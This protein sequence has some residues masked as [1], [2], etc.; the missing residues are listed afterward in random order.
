MSGA[1]QDWMGARALGNGAI[2]KEWRD[3]LLDKYFDG[4]EA[5]LGALL[6]GSERP[7][8]IDIGVGTGVCSL[9]FLG[10]ER[11]NRSEYFGIDINDCVFD[12][13][14]YFLE[15]GVS[16]ESI[17]FQQ[18]DLFDL[19]NEAGQFDLILAEG[20]LHHTKSL[21]EAIEQCSKRLKVGGHLLFYVSR[22]PAPLRA[23]SDRLIRASLNGLSDAEALE[24]LG[25][26]SELGKTLGDLD[27]WIEVKQPI[28]PLGIPAGRI[29]LQ[30]L[31]YYYVAK[32]Y[33]K[34]GWSEEDLKHANFDWFRQLDC[35]LHSPEEIKAYVEACGLAVRRFK[36][37]DSGVSVVA[38]RGVS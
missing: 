31:F 35:Q 8:I 1:L 9:A 4:D 25:P 23:E 3:W 16:A 14:R 30:R 2:Q 15:Q 19:G 32:A 22:K 13:R 12:A 37:E 18:R 34:P 38:Y 24:A 10:V 6:S 5:R 33:Y 28:A 27:A 29:S 20:V 17:C 21:Q 11:I 7:R 26:L 36:V